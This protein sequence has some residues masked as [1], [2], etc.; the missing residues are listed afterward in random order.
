MHFPTHEQK[1]A[2]LEQVMR[3]ADQRLQAVPHA[4]RLLRPLRPLV[5]G[6]PA[7]PGPAA[8]DRSTSVPGR[9]RQAGAN[10]I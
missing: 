5:D 1:Q 2:L 8:F 6:G 4:Q 7:A 3:F 10:E 9:T